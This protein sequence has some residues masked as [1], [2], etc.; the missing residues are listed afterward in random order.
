MPRRLQQFDSSQRLSGL[1]PLLALQETQQ[2]AMF[3]ADT[4]VTSLT[5]C[6]Q[7]A[8]RPRRGSPV[9]KSTPQ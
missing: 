2:R 7:D 3:V 1:A 4:I 6:S 5:M 9:T 8:I